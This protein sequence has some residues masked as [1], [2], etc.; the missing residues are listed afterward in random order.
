LQFEVA[1]VV[2]REQG[3]PAPVHVVRGTVADAREAGR[4]RGIV[5]QVESR[6]RPIEAAHECLSIRAEAGS[7]FRVAN[8]RRNGG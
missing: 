6:E 2:L 3:E 1:V 8:G 4:R 5:Q 7:V